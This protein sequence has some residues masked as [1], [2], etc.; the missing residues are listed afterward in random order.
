MSEREY[1]CQACG[2]RSLESDRAKK[3][4]RYNST[5]CRFD[6]TA[7][8]WGS[9]LCMIVVNEFVCT[10][11]QSPI[12]L[13]IKCYLCALNL[14]SCTQFGLQNL[15][16][17]SVKTQILLNCSVKKAMYSSIYIPLIEC[18]RKVY[19]GKWAHREKR[20]EKGEFP[21][22]CNNGRH[23]TGGESCTGLVSGLF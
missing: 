13:V 7:T 17:H 21:R 15:L 2:M 11:V 9:A 3:C 6:I 20:N 8:I 1:K 23:C 19:H 4:V 18:V 22:L 5:Q 10:F 16:D 14:I 12:F